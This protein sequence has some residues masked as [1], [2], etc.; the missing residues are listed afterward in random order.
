MG[1]HASDNGRWG[2]EMITA[3]VLLFYVGL[4]YG[5]PASA[6]FADKASCEAAIVVAKSRWLSFEGFCVPKQAKQ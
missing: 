5:G 3:Y 4:Q 6:E 1:L 2:T